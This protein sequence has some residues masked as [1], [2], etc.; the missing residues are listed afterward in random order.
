MNVTLDFVGLNG[1]KSINKKKYYIPYTTNKNDITAESIAY[2][3]LNNVWKLYSLSLSLT[4]D[5]GS[6]FILKV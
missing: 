2:L 1:N 6:Q 5:W 4:S 3:L